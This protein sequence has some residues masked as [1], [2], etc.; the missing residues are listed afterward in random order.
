MQ[1]KKRPLVWI[2][3]VTMVLSLFPQGLFSSNVASAA[4][5]YSTYFTP[6]DRTIRE[7]SRL[8]LVYDSS[9]GKDNS[10]FLSRELVYKSP[11]SSLDIT[12]TFAMVNGT[13]LK[14]KVEQLKLVEEGNLRTW[15][16]DETRAVTTAITDS[17]SNRFTAS[18]VSLFSGFN[19]ITFIGTQGN[20]SVES[21]DAF[22][23]MYDPA[24]YI[25]NF[26]LYTDRTVPGGGIAYNLNEGTETVVDT[27]RVDFQGSVK[28]AT[29]VSISVNGGEAIDPPVTSDGSFFASQIKL[30]PGKNILK[31]KIEGQ[32]NAIETERIVYYFDTTKP[33][34]DLKVTI[35]TETKSVLSRSETATFTD[36]N[37]T[38]AKLSGQV[39]IPYVEGSG[40][41]AA[42]GTVT[43]QGKNYNVTINDDDEKL[44]T[45]PDGKSV[46]YRMVNFTSNEEYDLT[47][48][49]TNTTVAA[50]NQTLVVKVVQGAFSS[51]Y[52]TSFIY[53]SGSQDITNLY[54]LPNYKGGAIDSKTPLNGATLQEDKLY[55]LVESGSSLKKDTVPTLKGV[56][57]PSGLKPVELKLYNGATGLEDNEQVYEVTNLASGKQQLRFSFSDN[58]EPELAKVVE[59]TYA[60]ISSIYVGSIQTGET[61]TF[62][63]SKGTQYLN[64]E[65]ELLGFKDLNGLK[66]EM[67]VNGQLTATTAPELV[68]STTLDTPTA[69]ATAL[70]IAFPK[71][72]KFKFSLPIKK[73]GPIYYGENTIEIRAVVDDAGGRPKTI[74]TVLKIN[75]IDTYSSTIASFMPTRIPTTRESFDNKT[76]SNYT[77]EKLSRI[78][79]VTPDF[80]LKDGKYVTSEKEF[81]LVFRG[82]GAQNIN[83]SFGSKV[84]FSKTVN[85]TDVWDSKDT[86]Q[87]ADS[88]GSDFAGNEDSFIGRIRGL[89]FDAPGTQVYTLELINSTGARSTQRIEIV[90]EPVP[91]R[92]LA[93]QPTVGDQ[94]V[95][96]KNY[97]RFDIEAEGATQVLIGKEPAEKR[98]DYN[99][100]FVLDYV[101]LKPDKEN[102]IKIEITRDGGT[103]SDTV[104]VYYTSA[105]TTGSQYMAPK[106]ANKYTA[107]NKNVQLSFPK[108][109]VLQS[110]NSIGVT[111]FYPDNKLLFGIAEPRKGIVEKINDYGYDTEVGGEYK[112]KIEIPLSVSS[113]F[114]STMD[115]SDFTLISDIYWIN[116]G[117]GEQGNRSDSSYKSATDGVTPYSMDGIFTTFA[118]E[119]ILAPSNRGSLILNYDPSIVDDVGSTIT[120]FRLSDTTQAGTW[121][122]IGGKVDTKKHTITV[123][124][125]EFGYYKV[126]K[127]S[128]S[129]ADI[130]NH[131]WARNYLNA[132]YA[133]GLMKPLKTNSFGADDRITRGEFATLLVKGMDIPIITPT[134]QTFSDVGKGTGAEIWSYEA[135]ETAARVGIIQGRSDGFFQPQLPVSRED[136]AVMIARAMNAKLAAND[137]KLA[138][139]LGKS[140]LDSSS[141]EY[142]ARPAIQAVTKAKIM[143]GSPITLPGATKPQYQ[144]NPKGNM[145]RAEAAKIAVELLK[146]STGLF[147]KTLS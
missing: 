138:A 7:S 118:A 88:T 51:E 41:F 129:Y 4:D 23:V 97:V 28:N 146:K 15:V 40:T 141:I 48:D 116:G 58:P 140:F 9:A 109:T 124:F 2:M 73:N 47:M 35:G 142:Y 131:P 81:D 56:Y 85:N 110:K 106:V 16:P 32:P 11:T 26:L 55:I 42:E 86:G 59:V 52:T 144:F 113:N 105:V 134:Q 76:V 68:N 12:G 95:V 43:V 13:S 100:R 39:L 65:G 33:F 25:E 128:R 135:I 126:M 120:V 3:L 96:N 101:G 38:K 74:S 54:Y 27:E 29:Q 89:K 6:S 20:S 123:P 69:S 66:A 24:P 87:T 77:E 14:V 17:G 94:I 67:L 83:L 8:S 1:Q 75:V 37:Q 49:A 99:N 114:S 34:V 104:T 107:F 53:S 119:R 92:I 127:Q 71:T 139:A 143:E 44:I 102:K 60:T 103:I 80:I 63:S 122:P 64:V 10:N 5:S 91:Y 121:V 133:K 98:T 112:P 79:A 78:F 108:G 130:T 90:R 84:I 93:P 70:V 62:D 117:I 82:S 115:T 132:M 45:G 19:K 18:N 61:Y 111:K 46:K 57:L 30:L 137:S 125:D 21:S 22:Y 72:Q 50:K 147:P 136:A 36:Q 145:T 31:F